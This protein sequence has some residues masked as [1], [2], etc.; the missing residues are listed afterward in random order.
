MRKKEPSVRYSGA[1]ARSSEE[2]THESPLFNHGDAQ[3]KDMQV[4][5][6]PEHK[7]NLEP[8]T[9]AVTTREAREVTLGSACSG[10]E[11]SCPRE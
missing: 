5:G 3:Q 11:E 7:P 2:F 6:V 8:P 9:D 10:D 4:P 1:F